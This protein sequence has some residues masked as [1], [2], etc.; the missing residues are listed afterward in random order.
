MDKLRLAR[1]WLTAAAI[2]GLAGCGADSPV[3]AGS[4]LDDVLGGATEDAALTDGWAFDHDAKAPD[5]WFWSDD[6]GAWLGPDGSSGSDT[7]T[8]NDGAVASDGSPG[9]DGTAGKDSQNASDGGAQPGTLGGFCT[10]IADCPEGAFCAAQGTSGAYCTTWGCASN[11]QCSNIPSSDLMCCVSYGNGAQKQ[12]YCLKQYGATQCGKQDQPV[13][14]DCQKGGQSDCT[15]DANWCFQTNGGSICVQ[16]CTKLN[17]SVCATGTT[18]NVFPTGAGCLPFT[19]GVADGSPCAQATLGGCGKYAFCIESYPGDPLAYCATA[20]KQDA[21]CAKGLSCF[22]YD[23]TQGICQH[24]GAKAVGENCAGDRFS[25]AKG[26]YCVGF[27]G[28]SAVCAPQCTADAD[29]APLA[30]STGGD[31]YC[32]KNAG[33]P[34]GI[35]YPKGPGANGDK[36]ADNPYLCGEGLYCIGGYDTYNPGAFCQKSCKADGICPPGA[37][38]MTYTQDYSGCQ[39]NGKLGQGGDCQGDSTLCQAGEFCIGAGKT[40]QC[41][42]QCTLNNPACPSGTW[43]MPYGQD[44]LGLCWPAG[45]QAVGSVCQGAPWDCQQGTLCSSYGVAKDAS[46]LENCDGKSCPAGFSCDNFGESGHWCQPVGAGG[47]G[48]ACSLS[49]PCVSGDVCVGQDGPAPFCAKQCTADS[50]CPG[51]DVNGQKLWCAKGKWGGFCVPNGGTA[52]N[53]LCYGQPWSCAKGLI[54][55]GDS[56]SNPGAF[57]AEACSGFASVCAAGEKCEYLGGGD[58]FC[59]KTGMLPTGSDCLA[60]PLGCAPDA[61]CIKGSPLPLCVQQCGVGFATCPADSPCT[62]FVGSPIKLCVPKG[63]IPFGMISAPF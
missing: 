26:L 23:G 20:C 3:A 17:D 19:A 55:L 4:S 56:A 41:M 8:L 11:S 59:F 46:C 13:G 32:A 2:L 6:A 30:K 28:G 37:T 35:C 45:N 62:S 53:G 63:F 9:Q 14:G 21:D 50:D 29:C 1:N 34:S 10:T 47:Q 7:S 18:C 54:C 39:P 22:I 51:A 36:C 48:A 43:C 38:C 58:A 52:K 49:A 27:G 44:N 5:G 42:T 15:G 31:A 61:L 24:N 25:C 33:N 16:N 12:S 60:D 40:W 57:C